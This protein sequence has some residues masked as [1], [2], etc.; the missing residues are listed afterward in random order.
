MYIH[1]LDSVLQGTNSAGRG[2]YAYIML[3]FSGAS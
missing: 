3:G 1:C 2:A